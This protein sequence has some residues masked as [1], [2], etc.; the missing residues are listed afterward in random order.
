VDERRKQHE[1]ARAKAEKEK[2]IKR[3]RGMTEE[4]CRKKKAQEAAPK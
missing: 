3:A 2:W 4:E 1:E